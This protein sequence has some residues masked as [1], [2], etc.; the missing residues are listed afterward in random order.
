MDE[1]HDVD[2]AG[3]T[4]PDG[5]PSEDNGRYGAIEMDHGEVV[6]YDQE[7]PSAWLQ[8]DLAVSLE[9]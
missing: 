7:D 2:A 1:R 8:S 5:E 6:I 4:G 9:A 3:R